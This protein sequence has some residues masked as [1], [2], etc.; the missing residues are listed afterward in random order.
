MAKTF[1]EE[2]LTKVS[3]GDGAYETMLENKLYRVKSHGENIYMYAST[4]MELP[5]TNFQFEGDYIVY[6]PVTS[7]YTSTFKTIEERI[8]NMIEISPFPSWYKG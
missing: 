2:E 4:V 6:D 1:N 5:N 3:G 8:G 7:T